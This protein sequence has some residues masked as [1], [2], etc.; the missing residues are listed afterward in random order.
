VP[1]NRARKELARYAIVLGFSQINRAVT[2]LA[3]TAP[4]R[5]L[6]VDEVQ[7]PGR[8]SFINTIFVEAYGSTSQISQLVTIWYQ[9]VQVCPPCLRRQVQVQGRSQSPT[10]S[11]HDWIACR[12]WSTRSPATYAKSS[13]SN[14]DSA[15][16]SSGSSSR[17][18][19]QH[20]GSHA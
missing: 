20:D 4:L 2:C 16:P 12:S 18:R 19:A 17:S 1:I 6:R 14:R 8:S 13:S 15:C 9:I 5:P 3:G 10:T 11:P 7:A